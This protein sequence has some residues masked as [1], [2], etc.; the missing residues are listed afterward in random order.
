MSRP[1]AERRRKQLAAIHAAMRTLDMDNDTYRALL[2]RVSAT[3]GPAVRSAGQ[4]NQAQTHA[5]LEELKRLGGLKPSPKTKGKPRNFDSNAM[6][7]MI[8]KVEALLA[9]MQLSW[10]YADAIAKRQFGIERVAWCR[11]QD[12]LRSIIAALHVEHE[13]RAL[14]G[15][16]EH[17]CERVGLTLEQLEVRYGLG[18]I[19]G[20]R[21]NRKALKAVGEALANEFPETQERDDG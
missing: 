13:K 6:P 1:E 20:W 16:V 12:Q 18:G 11:T 3:A 17:T 21:R 7:E 14:L 15:Y 10:S 19:K 2:E 9:D 8:T 4:L 5:V